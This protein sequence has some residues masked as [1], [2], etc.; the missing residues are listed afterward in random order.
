MKSQAREKTFKKI[1]IAM[2]RAVKQLE[3]GM[4]AVERLEQAAS[5]REREHFSLLVALA[6][7]NS[8]H[9]ITKILR[10]IAIDVDNDMPKGTQSSI[11]L[12]NRM[13][14]RTNERPEI[15][16]MKYFETVGRIGRFHRDFRRATLLRPN[17]SDSV[18]YLKAISNEILPDMIGNV[19]KLAISSSHDKDF[20]MLLDLEKVT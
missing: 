17:I 2:L 14:E 7:H 6:V 9:S 20:A 18:N 4:E 5:E 10:R 15:I 19:R 11:R 8:W 13:N 16:S 1:R 3:D 12:I